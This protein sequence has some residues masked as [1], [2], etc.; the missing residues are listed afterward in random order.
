MRARMTREF[1]IPADSVEVKP[2]GIDAVAYYYDSGATSQ[3]P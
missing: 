3:L 2:E 1:Y